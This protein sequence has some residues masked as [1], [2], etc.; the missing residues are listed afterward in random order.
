MSEGVKWDQG[1]APH[2]LLAAEWLDGTARV[3]EFGAKKYGRYNWAKGMAWSRVFAALMR[4]LWKWWRGEELDDETNESHLYHATCC[5]MFLAEYNKYKI[6][7]DDRPQ[8]SKG[9]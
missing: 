8:Y 6:G 2:D 1:K 9:S 5:L 4:H 3:L 7:E